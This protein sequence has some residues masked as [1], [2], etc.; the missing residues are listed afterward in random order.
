MRTVQVSISIV[1]LSLLAGS[2]IEAAELRLR[3][4]EKLI[5]PV[6]N[7]QGLALD[8]PRIAETRIRNEREVELLGKGNGDGTLS[9]FTADGKTQSYSIHVRGGRADAGDGDEDSAS[10]AWPKVRFGGRRIP[11]A[12]CGEPAQAERT[13]QVFEEARGLLKKE[14][15][16]EAIPKLDQVLKIEPTA[17]FAHLFLGAAWAKLNDQAQGALHYETF[18]LSCPDDPKVE[19]VV[20]LL[21]EFARR[22]PQGKPKP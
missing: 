19:A 7:A 10:E 3:A 15:T 5:L 22:T 17:A 8:N 4:G 9:I 14:Q 2:A 11:D 12:H 16:Q 13:N 21:R 20:N 1:Y 6:R 18:V